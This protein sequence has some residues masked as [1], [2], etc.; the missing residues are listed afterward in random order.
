MR[1]IF[2]GSCLL[3]A[4]SVA[5]QQPQ[6]QLP[7]AVQPAT[8]HIQTNPPMR[9][10]I[11]GRFVGM[12]PLQVRLL[13]ATYQVTLATAD[14]AHRQAFPITL[15]PG[16]VLR[17]SR[18]VAQPFGI[19]GQI[20]INLGGSRP[21]VRPRPHP[22]QPPAGRAVIYITSSRPAIVHVDGRVAGRAPGRVIVQPGRHR[23]TLVTPDGRRRKLI[24]RVQPG[25]VERRHVQF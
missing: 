8:F 18:S 6:E 4:G 9:V 2:F 25:Q 10:E 7:A 16:Q 22:A 17:V 3:A 12:S 11:D 21:L 14:G 5:A 1:A 24:V 23:I 15:A 13:P 20:S 19:Q